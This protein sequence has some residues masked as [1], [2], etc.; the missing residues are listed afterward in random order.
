MRATVWAVSRK[1]EFWRLVKEMIFLS[2]HRSSSLIC[3][4]T[5]SGF[6]AHFRGTVPLPPSGGRSP[7]QRQCSA[8]P[9]R[10]RIDDRR[11]IFA[12]A[13]D[14]TAKFLLR[15][16][17]AMIDDALNRGLQFKKYGSRDAYPGKSS[18]RAGKLPMSHMQES[19]AA[20]PRAHTE[21]ARH[22]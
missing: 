15:S 11:R 14:P 19:D 7:P 1:S 16:R 4:A 9:S 22:N 17:N 3:P 18:S 10:E 13:R 8:R 21:S 6:G 2:A 20:L 12:M 5:Q